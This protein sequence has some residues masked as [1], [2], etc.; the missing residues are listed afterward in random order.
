M[1]IDDFVTETAG[2]EDE[3]P[4]DRNKSYDYLASMPARELAY[5]FKTGTSNE[6]IIYTAFLKTKSEQYNKEFTEASADPLLGER[7]EDEFADDF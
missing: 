6:I 4:G 1:R 5:Y 3:I 2:G 7:D